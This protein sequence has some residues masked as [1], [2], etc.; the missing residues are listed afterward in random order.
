LRKPE[1]IIRSYYKNLYSLKLDNQDEMDNFLD[2]CQVPK[3][4]QDQINN[5]NSP[6]S[7]KEIEIVINSLPNKK[8][9]G[10]DR[11][12]AD[13]YQ[14]FKEDLIPI[15][16]KIFHNIETDGSLLKSF[17]VAI[18][19]LIPNHPKTQQRKRSSEQVPF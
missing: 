17:Y 8:C 19:T 11:F 15:L 18:I 3:L 9:A 13:F 6:I 14:T 5:Q 12:N 2:R 16:I 1:K 10:P 7:L 4:N